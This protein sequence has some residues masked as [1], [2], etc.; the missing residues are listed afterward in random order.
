LHMPVGSHIICWYWRCFFCPSPHLPNHAYLSP[1]P[2]SKATSST[3]PLVTSRFTVELTTSFLRAQPITHPKFEAIFIIKL[4]Y[5]FACI[6]LWPLLFP[7]LS[8]KTFEEGN[9]AVSCQ[10]SLE[11]T[12]CVAHS[13]C[14]EDNSFKL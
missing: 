13:K 11:F 3:K 10:Y 5:I 4:W 7:Y 1:I 8:F 12:L 6:Y 2:H 9:Q 14:S